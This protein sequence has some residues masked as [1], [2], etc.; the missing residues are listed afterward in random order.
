MWALDLASLRRPTSSRQEEIGKLEQ[1]EFGMVSDLPEGYIYVSY[2]GPLDPENNGR[3]VAWHEKDRAILL[4]FLECLARAKYRE[5]G[6]AQSAGLRAAKSKFQ[7]MASF[8]NFLLTQSGSA[9]PGWKRRI[10]WALGRRL[11]MASELD[12]PWF[13]SELQPQNESFSPQLLSPRKIWNGSS[14]EFFPKDLRRNI[15]FVPV[16]WWQRQ[17]TG[18]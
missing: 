5:E 14:K 8:A 7:A 16:F 17:G 13:T 10:L 9:A 12:E 1:P 6:L 11:K 2:G 4:T 15:R 18:N 3:W